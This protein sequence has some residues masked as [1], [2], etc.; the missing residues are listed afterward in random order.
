MWTK[1]ALKS[2]LL[3]ILALGPLSGSISAGETLPLSSRQEQWLRE[4]PVVTAG[5]YEKGWMPFEGVEGGT[6]QGLAFA[7]LQDA[8]HRLGI[9]VHV[10]MYSDWESMMADACEG[11]LDIVLTVALTAER[12]RCLIYTRPYVTA[13][14]A[15]VGRTT[16]A[17]LG[18]TTEFAGLRII[19][20]R[21]FA[22]HEAARVRFTLASHLTAVDTLEALRAVADKRADVYVG[23]PYV[24]SELIAQHHLENI[25]LLRPSDLP[26]DSLH[27]AVPNANAPLAEG[28]DVAMASF[29]E[30]HTR[31]LRTRWL[32]PLEWQEREVTLSEEERASL[33]AVLR[34][35]VASDWAPIAFRDEQGRASGLAMD[36]LRR[37]QA[38]GAH[39]DLQLAPWQELRARAEHGDIDLLVGLA[40]DL[41]ASQPWLASDAFLSVPNVIVT[42]S[43]DNVVIDSGDLRGRRIATSD[44]QRVGSR[45]LPLAPGATLLSIPDV[46]AGLEAVR[47]SRADAYVGNL[48]LVDRVLREKY[49]GVLQISAPAG[50]EDRL[51]LAAP[52]TRHSVLNTF[53]RMLL[54]LSPRE[55]EGIR[56]DW[57]AVEYRSGLQWGRI[58]AWGL[59]IAGLLALSG[60]A[61]GVVHFR[62][63]QEVNQRRQAEQQLTEVGANLPAVVYQAA[64][65]PDGSVDL[66]FIAGDMASLFGI[67]AEEA[68]CDEN[69]I[70]ERVH[71]DDK[72]RLREA[73]ELALA[74]TVPL[75][76]EFRAKAHAGWRWIRSRSQPRSAPGCTPVWTGYWIDVTYAHEQAQALADAKAS[77]E[78]AT[79][80]KSDFLATMS[81][82]IRTPMSGILGTLEILAHTRLDNEQ[83]RILASVDDS[84]QMLRQILDDVLDLSKIEAGALALAPTAVDLRVLVTNVQQLLLPQASSKGLL[85][86]A[87]VRDSVAP[88]HFVDANR[89]RQVLLNLTSNAIKFTPQGSVSIALEVVEDSRASQTLA[90]SVTDTGIGIAPEHQSRLFAPF[91]QA[92]PTVSRMYGGTG[93]GLSIC[94]RLVELM[95]GEIAL[96]SERQ[97]GTC[98]TVTVP[99][100]VA[101][102]AAVERT[103]QASF[104]PPSH[105]RH[106]RV[107]VAE[108]HPT[109]QVVMS[110]RLGQLGLSGDIVEDGATA[111]QRYKE[112]SYDLLISDCLMP[113]MD[114]YA[115]ARA[116]R[117][118]EKATNRP[119]MPIVALSA[120]AFAEDAAR[121]REAGMDDFLAKPVDLATLRVTLTR[122]LSPDAQQQQCFQ[123]STTIDCPLGDEPPSI[124]KLASQFGS[125]EVAKEMM[126]AWVRA[127]EKD[128]G[129]LNAGLQDHDHERVVRSLHSLIGGFGTIQDVTRANEARSLMERVIESSVEKCEGDLRRYFEKLL[130]YSRELRSS[131]ER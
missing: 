3:C 84:A 78:R 52:S 88:A 18:A 28:I 124:E 35:G 120:N 107:L 76:V 122:W 64:P 110:W 87:E 108:D 106:C 127:V 23:N 49:S 29:P 50:F 42:R 12:T 38:L 80:A 103:P 112:Q 7:T 71:P 92:D 111:L 15:V 16:D 99:F 119:R 95:G 53:N 73:V 27:L 40:D 13:P 37:L 83:R 75:D 51:V 63:R 66:P 70:F 1:V 46:A 34:I 58:L 54:S 130:A 44:P 33:G 97:A 96:K 115:L 56:G 24:A 60:A 74:N 36:Y 102:M 55:R 118:W 68:I 113:G 10:R 30:A 79:A 32:K 114:G 19:T 22:T 82:E 90:L 31:A 116:V 131:V 47:T 105:W 6:P 9:R 20:E 8:A 81:H 109:N 4:H 101:P 123:A 59:P 128:M 104:A 2:A 21:G 25:G 126:A 41:P 72:E 11:R 65:R 121:C 86:V 77:A 98:V 61:F 91:T 89:L 39:L 94:R 125:Y 129:E 85:L 45:L 26:L 5:M 117:D 69:L 67:T 100:D 48:A 43:R 93:L 62:L 17:H 14:V 57:L